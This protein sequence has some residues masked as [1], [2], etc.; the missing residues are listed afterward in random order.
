MVAAEYYAGVTVRA[1]T[2]RR[3]TALN[4]NLNPGPC[5]GGTPLW[6]ARPAGRPARG[7]TERRHGLTGVPDAGGPYAPGPAGLR[8]WQATLFRRRTP[9]S[10]LPYCDLWTPA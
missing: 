4:D 8:L 6:P 3:L 1:A 7:S 9:P 10:W 5:G 2:S